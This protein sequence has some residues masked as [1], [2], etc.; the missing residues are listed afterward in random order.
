[1]LKKI[2]TP[3][4]SLGFISGAALAENT[5]YNNDTDLI[6]NTPSTTISD[7]ERLSPEEMKNTEGQ[8]LPLLLVLGGGAISSWTYHGINYLNHGRL[9]TSSGAAWAAGAGML[10]GVHGGGLA[11]YAGLQG[12]PKA[13][14]A[15][16]G[17]GISA[18][19]NAANPW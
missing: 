16:R 14:T 5:L 4:I 3:L 9:G 19:W 8:L 11:T 17:F 10:G 1:M 15:F 13:Y 12:A 2:F 6:F 7:F 18:T